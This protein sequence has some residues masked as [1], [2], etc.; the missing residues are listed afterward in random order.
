MKTIVIDAGHGG[1][2]GGAI[3]G[4]H[5]EKDKNLR[6]AL[7]V[8]KYLKNQGVNVVMT[9]TEDKYLTLNERSNI[10]NKVN[11]DYCFSLHMDSAT[12]T[13]SGMSIWLYSKA[14][15]SMISFAGDILNEL[16]KVGFL[17][18][19]AKEIYKGFRD[20]PKVDYAWN[21][22]T[23]SPSMLLELGFISNPTNVKDM[24]EKYEDYAKAICKAICKKIDVEYKEDKI[25]PTGFYKVQLGAFKDRANAVALA[26][27]LGKLG[28]ESIIK[29]D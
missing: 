1:I 10:E 12:A 6:M 24:D 29:I 26:E 13:A 16:K 17:T 28:F 18:N 22:Q 27:K 9:R 14:S 4:V 20:N 23:K 2:D 11:A 3:S 7:T 19:R 15:E 25:E 5:F 8:E 21:R